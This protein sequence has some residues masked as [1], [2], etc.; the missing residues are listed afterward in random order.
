MASVAINSAINSEWIEALDPA[1]QR[2]YFISLTT[3]Q[4]AWEPP[5][6]FLDRKELTAKVETLSSEVSRLEAECSDAAFLQRVRDTFPPPATPPPA[7][8]GGDGGAASAALEAENAELRARVQALER[9]LAAAAPAPVKAA[10]RGTAP[11]SLVMPPPLPGVAPP[12][13]QWARGASALVDEPPPPPA[14]AASLAKS[15]SSLHVVQEAPAMPPPLPGT[16]PPPLP[17]MLGDPQKSGRS[18]VG[19]SFSGEL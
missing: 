16:E 15:K 5:E 1:T 12:K 18:E 19:Q 9:E 13:P 14:W 3:H 6:G 2:M 11:P 8:G 7:A 10:R 4:T 17:P